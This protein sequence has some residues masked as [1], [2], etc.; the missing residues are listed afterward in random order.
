MGDKCLKY[1]K[2]YKI[3]NIPVYYNH[4]VKLS[5]KAKGDLHFSC[6][7]KIFSTKIKFWFIHRKYKLHLTS[8]KLFSHFINF[9]IKNYETTPRCHIVINSIVSNSWTFNTIF[10]SE[11][12]ILPSVSIVAQ[13]TRSWLSSLQIS[14]I[15]LLFQN[16]LWFTDCV[17]WIFPKHLVSA[18]SLIYQGTLTS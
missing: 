16:P 15:V 3:V 6:I 2:I 17:K 9:I 18:A 13:I 10:N 8:Q 1:M 14:D 12:L 11:F 4:K 5:L 7:K